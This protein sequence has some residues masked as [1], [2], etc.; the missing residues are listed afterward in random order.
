M[1]TISGLIKNFFFDNFSLLRTFN[2]IRRN[3]NLK[4]ADKT[5]T[6]R[7]T[8]STTVIDKEIRVEPEGSTRKTKKTSTKRPRPKP[9]VSTRTKRP[10]RPRRQKDYVK[11]LRDGYTKTTT[12]TLRRTRKVNGQSVGSPVVLRTRKVTKRSSTKIDAKGRKHWKLTTSAEMHQE[13]AK[14]APKE[15]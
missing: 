1:L 5:E 12:R 14:N 10:M 8:S 7:E 13:E 3:K 11:K 9:S 4:M 2:L 15:D 6:I